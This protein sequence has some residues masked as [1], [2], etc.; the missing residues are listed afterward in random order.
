MR[1][2]RV[3]G[4]YSYNVNVDE[5]RNGLL[6]IA[7]LPRCTRDGIMASRLNIFRDLL[8]EYSKKYHYLNHL[9]QK[10]MFLIESFVKRFYCE[11]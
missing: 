4:K 2:M 9:F 7:A 8:R 6:R 10:E 11:R 3:H 1:S 5:R